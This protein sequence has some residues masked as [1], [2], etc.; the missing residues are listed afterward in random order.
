MSRQ[1]TREFLIEVEKGNIPG[2]SIINKFGKH[3]DVGYTFEPL[4]IHGIYNTPQPANAVTLRVKAGDVDDDAGGDG[5]RLIT[6]QG[7]DE[8]GAEVTEDIAPNGTS[9]GIASTT[10][11]IRM[12]RAFVAE[13]GT[14]A[15]EGTEEIRARLDCIQFHSEKPVIF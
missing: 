1:F 5:A 11:W 13:S 10:T 8:T 12:P 3:E 6:L 15:S 2:H 9:S 4:A 7:L 14:Y